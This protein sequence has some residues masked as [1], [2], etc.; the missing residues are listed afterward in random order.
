MTVK[1]IQFEKIYNFRDMGGAKTKDGGIVKKGV[2]FRSGDLANATENDVKKLEQLN[3]KV[4]F[5]YRDEFEAKLNTSPALNNVKNIRIPAK[6]DNSVIPTAN[7]EELLKNKIFL[8]PNILGKFY[9]EMVF[10]NASYHHLLNVIT[11]KNV[12]LLHHCAAGKDRTGV[13]AALIY[14]L[15]DVPEDEII[16]DYLRTNDENRSNPPQWFLQMKEKFKEYEEVFNSLSGVKEE[17]IQE[18]FTA[19]KSRYPDYDTFFEK[20][21]GITKE[22]KES[23]K[24]YYLV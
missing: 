18:V 11:K 2:L 4:I 1:M 10:D 3:L 8:Q 14:L 7:M 24:N 23:A 22:M 6:K 19:I 15:L 12:P 13:G 21:Y 9:A 17:Y 20:E 5:D 16:A